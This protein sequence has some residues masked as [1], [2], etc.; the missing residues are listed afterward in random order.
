[1]GD[2][3]GAPCCSCPSYDLGRG[4]D[5]VFRSPEEADSNGLESE[6]LCPCQ[7]N[8]R[9]HDSCR[10]CNKEDG[11]YF[12]RVAVIGGNNFS[13]IATADRAAHGAAAVG[14]ARDV[15]AASEMGEMSA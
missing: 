5:L 13:P 15:R 1:M 12:V 10:G 2:S 3:A 8:E 4:Q 9:V 7:A 6:S 14:G 11:G